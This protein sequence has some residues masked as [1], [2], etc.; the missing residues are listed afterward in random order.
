VLDDRVVVALAGLYGLIE[1]CKDI[2]E[3]AAKARMTADAQRK[4]RAP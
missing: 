2:R 1:A 4:S 3:M